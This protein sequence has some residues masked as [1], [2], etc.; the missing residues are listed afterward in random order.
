MGY[1]V[2][3]STMRDPVSKMQNLDGAR[4]ITSEIVL[5]PPHTPTHVLMRL[6][7]RVS[8]LQLRAEKSKFM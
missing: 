1:L 7:V 6:G 8:Y 5:W 2:N 3:T 4:E